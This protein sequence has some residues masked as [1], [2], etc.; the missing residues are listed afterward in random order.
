VKA[1]TMTADAV[2][3]E[4]GAVAIMSELIKAR[5]TLLVVLTTLVGFY[6]GAGSVV[7]VRLMVN[8]VF[9]TALVASGAA[10][11]N[12]VLERKH[13][14]RMRRTAGRPLPS[15]RVTPNAALMLGVVLSVAG[16]AWLLFTVNPLTALLGASTHAC[17]IFIYTPLKRITVLNT[18]VGAVPGALPPLM[19]WTAATGELAAPGLSLSGLIFFWQLPHFMAI[20]WLY[21]HDYAGAGFKMLPGI[22]PRGRR[23]AAS[24]IRN[25]FA[26]VVASLFPFLLGVAGKW[27]LTVAVAA[28]LGVLAMA[29]RFGRHLNPGAARGLFLASIIYLPLMLGMLVADKGAKKLTNPSGMPVID[30]RPN[31]RGD[32]HQC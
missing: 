18:L 9:G 5:L 21:R 15:G 10:V 29:F 7:D 8:A 25:S 6:L 26:L 23:T 30:A 13:D 31:S 32:A 3:R 19:G 11:L 20:A 27:Y 1:I 24:A 16:L 17:Y 14:A 4:K 22:D 28:G 12:Q 2:P